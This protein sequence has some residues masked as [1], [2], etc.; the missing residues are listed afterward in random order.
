MDEKWIAEDIGIPLDQYDICYV[1][2]DGNG[3]KVKLVGDYGEVEIIFYSPDSV[4]ITDEGRRLESYFTVPIL[5]NYRK[6][7]IGNPFFII[8]NSDYVK[9]IENE[10]LG[11]STDITHYVIVTRDDIVDIISSFPPKIFIKSNK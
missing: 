9:W 2:Q 8:L 6:N 7:F 10:S 5:Q 11:F 4:R 1:L 3:T